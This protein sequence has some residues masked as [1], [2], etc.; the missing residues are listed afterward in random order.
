MLFYQHLLKDINVYN[1]I[2]NP[3]IE[4][5]NK[6]KHHHHH[7]HHKYGINLNILPYLVL[8]NIF[9]YLK[10]KEILQLSEM[11]SRM[12]KISQS[13]NL[14]MYYINILLGNIC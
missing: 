4:Y 2:I 1:D 6:N 5:D 9:E 10:P 11:S 8:H 12:Y 3:I 7:H 13:N 14:W